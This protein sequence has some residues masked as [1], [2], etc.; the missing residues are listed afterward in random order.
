PQEDE[1]VILEELY[2]H[3]GQ[4][5]EKDTELARFSNRDLRMK[6]LQATREFEEKQERLAALEPEFLAARADK[7]IED[8]KKEMGSA[9][10]ALGKAKEEARALK[11]RES[12]EERILAPRAGIVMGLP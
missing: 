3:D 1:K 11:R 8:F 6:L 5:V 2:V 10:T 9:R 4:L 7:D 12:Q